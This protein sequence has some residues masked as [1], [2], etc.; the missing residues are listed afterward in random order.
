MID[1]FL[2]VKV[3]CKN[4]TNLLSNFRLE[5]FNKVLTISVDE[6]EHMMATITTKKSTLLLTD[7]RTVFAKT[8]LQDFR[9]FSGQHF[10]SLGNR[11]S[12]SSLIFARL[13]L[14]SKS[15]TS[16]FFPFSPKVI[17]ILTRTESAENLHTSLNFM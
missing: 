11:H 10:P 1:L 3:V 14:S 4:W 5:L 8:A 6:S 16:K 7:L 15:V 13:I 9:Y 17:R 2:L 12:S